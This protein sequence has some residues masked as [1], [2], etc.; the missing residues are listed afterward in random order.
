MRV[1]EVNGKWRVNAAESIEN[2]GA[3]PYKEVFLRFE[4][5]WLGRHN[6]GKS[7]STP[8]TREKKKIYIY[9]L[10]LNINKLRYFR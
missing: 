6:Q 4:R 9:K 7:S 10:I 1:T 2:W 5:S 3:L 8:A